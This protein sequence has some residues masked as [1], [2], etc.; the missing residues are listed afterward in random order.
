MRAALAALAAGASILVLGG[1]ASDVVS[2]AEEARN[3]AASLGA[4]LRSSASSLGAGS[5]QACTAGGPQLTRLDSLAGRLAADPDQR[6]KLAPEV[7]ATVDRLGTAIG[8]RSELQPAVAA[9]R[10]LTQA[11]GDANE[12]AVVLAAR[13]TQVAVRSAQALCKLSG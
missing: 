8:D 4:D 11:I 1:C 2:G 9:G 6:A 3:S 12:T 5:R 7:R 10:D 13:Q